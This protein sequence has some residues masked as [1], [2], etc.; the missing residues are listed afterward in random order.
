MFDSLKGKF[1]STGP[2]QRE[3]DG[4][5]HA[6]ATGDAQRLKKFLD[7]NRNAVDC[8]DSNGQTALMMAVAHK[9]LYAAELLLNHGADAFKKN[10][11]GKSARSLAAGNKD[12]RMVKMLA[13]WPKTQ[14]KRKKAH[15]KEKKDAAR[16]KVVNKLLGKRMD[17]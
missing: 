2:S 3:V 16:K 1:N 8:K 4:F 12:M 5:T 15:E 11:A 10:A 17:K 14:K 6:A 7:K 13:Q 9:H